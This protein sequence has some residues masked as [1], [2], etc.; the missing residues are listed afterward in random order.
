MSTAPRPG[1]LHPALT[2]NPDGSQP[3]SSELL[4]AVRALARRSALDEEDD[5]G[6]V[7]PAD[8]QSLHHAQ[9]HQQDGGKGPEVGV[10]GQH[11][12]QEGRD[13]HRQHRDRQRRPPADS[14]AD[15]TEDH[16]PDRAHQEAGGDGDG[17]CEEAGL[18]EERFRDG[19]V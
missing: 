17:G 3:G 18:T 4:A 5:R 1:Q 12:D 10:A 6:G 2:S 9:Q 11:A 16:P 7:L 14:V 13:G 15:V 8:R 19:A